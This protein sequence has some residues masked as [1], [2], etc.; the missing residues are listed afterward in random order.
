LSSDIIDQDRAVTL[1]DRRARALGDA[2]RREKTKGHWLF[3]VIFPLAVAAIGALL[4]V[5]AGDEL[6]DTAI[7]RLVLDFAQ[8]TIDFLASGSAIHYL[9][10][11]AALVMVGLIAAVRG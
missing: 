8:P 11:C 1:T 9:I 4:G 2:L 7:G 10:G 6:A 5:V 3:G